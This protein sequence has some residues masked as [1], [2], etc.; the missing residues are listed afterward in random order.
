MNALLE[1]MGLSILRQFDPEAAHGLAIR[2]LRAGLTPTPGPVSTPRLAVELAGMKLPNPVGLAA[3]FD[4]NATAIAPLSKAGFG[5][6]EVGA[7]TPLPQPGNEQPRLF[8]LTEDRAAINRFGFNNDGMDAICAR[9]AATKRTIP[10][11][12]NL[13]ANKTSTDRATDFS[14]VMEAAKDHV[15]F[16]TVN[17]SSPN[18][19]K[20]RDLQ[21]KAALAGLLEGVMD[22]HGDTPVMLKIAPDLNEDEIADVAQVAQDAGVS[23]II[24]TNTTLSREGLQSVHKSEAGGLSGAPLFERSTRVLARLSTLTDVPIIGVGGISNADQAY[25]KICAGASAVQLYTALVFGGLSMVGTIARG[26]DE[27]LERDGFA[28]V[29]DAIGSR[30]GEWL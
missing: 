11:G 2:A 18:T 20:L 22:V 17:V 8:R 9:I 4:K 7:A 16:A 14:R 19:E 5:F 6:I 28:T 12:L 13:G 21:G 10:V 24:A 25:A 29:S 15:D 3:G 27:R 1:A 23:A 26:I 30:K